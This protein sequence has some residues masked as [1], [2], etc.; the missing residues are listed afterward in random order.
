MRAVLRGLGPVAFL[1]AQQIADD[2][3]EAEKAF[4]RGALE[5]GV[6][7]AQGVLAIVKR[8]VRQQVAEAVDQ[9]FGGDLDAQGG[10]EFPQEGVGNVEA[11]PRAVVAAGGKALFLQMQEGA[12]DG[13]RRFS[14]EEREPPFGERGSREVERKGQRRIQGVGGGDVRLSGQHGKPPS[15]RAACPVFGIWRSHIWEKSITGV[16]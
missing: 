9:A 7:A 2:A 15:A 14:R 5:F 16:V 12:A 1:P 6:E 8:G 13:V 10:G 11:E 3:F 4:R